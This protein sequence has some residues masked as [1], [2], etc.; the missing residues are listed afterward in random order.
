MDAD[1]FVSLV[2][3]LS[4]APVDGVLHPRKDAGVVC[5]D[6]V[7]AVSPRITPSNEVFEDSFR[8]PA[9]A[10]IEPSTSPQ[11]GLISFRRGKLF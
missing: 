11:C 5:H 7:A 1:R 4:T 9:F 10:S 2:I 3:V 8:L 6:F